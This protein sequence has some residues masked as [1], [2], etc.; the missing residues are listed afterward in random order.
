MYVLGPEKLVKT[1]FIWKTAVK[2]LS[3]F[4]KLVSKCKTGVF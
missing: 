4:L 2:Q 1:S 3:V